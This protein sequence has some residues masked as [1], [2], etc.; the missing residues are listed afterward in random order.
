[1]LPQFSFSPLKCKHTPLEFSG[2]SDHLL[3]SQTSPINLHHKFLCSESPTFSETWKYFLY[4]PVI[5]E[6]IISLRL[7]EMRGYMVFRGNTF[8]PP[9]FGNCPYSLEFC[10][11]YSITIQILTFKNEHKK[12]TSLFYQSFPHLFIFFIL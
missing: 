4:S 9:L 1:M 2:P 8:S 11:E 7:K 12:L 5:V 3:T 10:L 6:C